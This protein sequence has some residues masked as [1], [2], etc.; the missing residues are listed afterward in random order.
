LTYIG[1]F[2]SDENPV[3]TSRWTIPKIHE[4]VGLDDDL[5]RQDVDCS[6]VL[7]S[8]Y[9]RLDAGAVRQL[10]GREHT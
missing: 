7:V 1:S 4:T 9:T 8:S 3:E 2:R 10:G 5:M 6:W